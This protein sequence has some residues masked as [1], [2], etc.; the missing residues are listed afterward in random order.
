MQFLTTTS[1]RPAASNQEL[2]ACTSAHEFA[3]WFRRSDVAFLP[4]DPE[5]DVG[6]H[7]L[8]CYDALFQIGHVSIPF[9]IAAC[10]HLYML[11]AIA[12]FPL[13]QADM[14]A[15]R[16]M[17]VSWVAAQR[18]LLANSGSDRQVR[19]NNHGRS[20]T[21]AKQQAGRLIVHG[22]K[23]FVTLASEA[24]LIIFTAQDEKSEEMLSLFAPLRNNPRISL[25]TSPFNGMLAGSATRQVCFHDLELGDENVIARG[26]A[27]FGDAHLFQRAWF[28]G[29]VGAVYLGAMSAALSYVANFARGVPVGQDSTLRDLDGFVQDMGR[30]RIARET[31]HQLKFSVAEA[32]STVS[33]APS[34]RAF[35]TLAERVLPSVVDHKKRLR[36]LI[37]RHGG[38]SEVAR[39]AGIPQPSLSRLLNDASR[40][41]R[42]TLYK[43]ARALDVE[44]SEIVG[45]WVR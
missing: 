6:S 5:I 45:E 31:A 12:Q 14:R 37:D 43:I 4:C 11:A 21:R 16:A 9:G 30:L 19:S 41:R 26:P 35:E 25:G 20:E 3:E 40:P 32:F 38:V 24:D 1:A 44:E 8:N 10:M 27:S 22:T 23:T 36:D 15:R 18:L 39:R 7:Y 2:A 33:L 13:E 28:Q 17:F 34:A 42:A 29:L